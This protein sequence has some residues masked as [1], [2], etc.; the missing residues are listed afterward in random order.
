MIASIQV[1]SYSLFALSSKAILPTQWS[2]IV[3]QLFR[4]D[5]NNENLTALSVLA[6]YYMWN[7]VPNFS[8][9]QRLKQYQRT[10]SPVTIVSVS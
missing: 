3:K 5:D 7:E 1:L 4:G 2:G 6:I 10:S 9:N 8:L